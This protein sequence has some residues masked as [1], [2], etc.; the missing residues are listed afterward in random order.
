[1]TTQINVVKRSYEFTNDEQ[2]VLILALSCQLTDLT[3]RIRR[4]RELG[5]LDLANQLSLRYRAN[6]QLLDELYKNTDFK[7]AGF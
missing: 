6:E 7:P 1:M 4:A 3:Q 2:K 5:R